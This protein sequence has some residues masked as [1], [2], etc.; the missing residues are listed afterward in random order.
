MAIAA[1]VV[2]IGFYGLQLVNQQFSLFRKNSDIALSHSHFEALLWHDF[3]TAQW[4][5]KMSDS[6][7]LCTMGESRVAYRFVDSLVIRTQEAPEP[8]FADTLHLFARPTEMVMDKKPVQKGLIESN[9]FLV[10]P[11]GEAHTFIVSKFYSAADRIAY[12]QQHEH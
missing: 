12:D 10:R 8:V 3:S 6:T 9:H 2:S 7:I 1:L 11:Y 4:V 5:E